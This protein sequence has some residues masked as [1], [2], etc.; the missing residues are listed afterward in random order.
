MRDTLFRYGFVGEWSDRSALVSKDEWSLRV[1]ARVQDQARA[2]RCARLGANDKLSLYRDLELVPAYGLRPS[3]DDRVNVEGTQLLTKCR[4]NHVMLMSVIGEMLCWPESAMQC[5]LCSSAKETVEH[6]L[7]DCPVLEL[8]RTRFSAE[9][10]FLFSPRV[11]MD[12][13]LGNGGVAA[14]VSAFA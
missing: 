9:L 4:L 13:S 6:F 5:L 1:D 2:A 8:C 10:Q 3:L 12:V 14:D 11:Q 7:L